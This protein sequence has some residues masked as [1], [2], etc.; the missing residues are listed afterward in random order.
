MKL[1]R[2]GTF[3]LTLVMVASL[4]V[5]P[6][7]AASFTDIDGHWSE[8]YV[9]TVYAAGMVSGYTDG[10]F[11]PDNQMT[12]CEALLFCSRILDLTVGNKASVLVDY[13]AD[14]S[15]VLP[16]DL[17]SWATTEMAYC[18]A[19][20]VI[21]L[22]ELETVSD[23]GNLTRTI[24]RET[25]A[26]YLCRA[27]QLA[28]LA[29]SLTTYNMTFDD[30]SSISTAMKP[31]VYLLNSYGIITGDE[32]NN[33]NPSAA[34][35]RAEMA[36]LLSRA[37]AFMTSRGI[38]VELA[39]YSGE[40][41]AGGTITSVSVASTGVATVVLTSEFS[42]ARSVVVPLTAKVYDYN[43]SS[44][45]SALQTGEYLRVIY[46]SSGTVTSARIG[47]STTSYEGDILSLTQNEIILLVDGAYQTFTIDYFTEIQAGISTVYWSELDLD[48]GYVTAT[49]TVDDLGHLASLQLG[50][51]TNVVE[52]IISDVSYDTSGYQ[53]IQIC[54]MS[55]TTTRYTVASTAAIT[56][57][58]GTTVSLS[59]THEGD[60]ATMRTSDTTG[61]VETLSIDTSSNYVQGVVKYYSTS[62]ETVSIGDLENGGYTTYYL[63]DYALM[64]YEDELF[65]DMDD[66]EK[67]WF[68]TATLVDSEV[69][70]LRMYE[71][72]YEVSGT[73]SGLTYGVITVMDV[74][75]DDGST[76]TFNLDMTDLPTI[77]RDSSSS[78]IDKLR[79]G[80]EVEVTVSDCEVTYIYA[81]PQDANVSGTI[82]KITLDST[83]AIIE[84]QIGSYTETYDVASSVTVSW[85]DDILT[86]NDLKPNYTI[87]LV[88]MDGQVV[89]I[90]IDDTDVSSKTI[91]G[92][93]LYTDTYYETMMLSVTDSSGS[94]SYVTVD[95]DNASFYY[96]DYGSTTYLS[97]IDPGDYIQVYGTYS[98][99]TFVA[100]L[101]I[102][103]TTA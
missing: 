52:G 40:V 102:L 57:A 32:T 35:T 5:L 21:S 8:S 13:S 24:D 66:L 11:R 45:T 33:F 23:A 6:A 37:D 3:L 7:S 65:T 92:T 9:E 84:L 69:T 88:V 20:G 55:G 100:T 63:S 59:S 29:E 30:T 91:S 82:N 28:P 98:G 46:N 49:C 31:Y 81:Y 14:V 95:V 75:L 42:G 50:G 83:G 51:G 86:V 22:S 72:D 1:K 19:A 27:M 41:W 56:N 36:T 103:I 99:S 73:I 94:N 25:L 15:A 89:S 4:F 34:L 17:T 16:E 64:Y 54:S 2:V 93:V 48:A 62:K 38:V 96:A 78:T 18:V 90:E 87:G 97:Y 79:T 61:E 53:T 10:T 70:I 80:D 76:M 12:Y 44:S 47:G 71:G 101:V 39:N 74:L 67:G 85:G 60:Y 58:S 68:I 26:M 43:L 77:Y